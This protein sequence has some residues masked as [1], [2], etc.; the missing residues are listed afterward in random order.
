[1]PYVR[2]VLDLL[3]MMVLTNTAAPRPR[4]ICS[5]QRDFVKPGLH[6]LFNHPGKQ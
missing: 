2:L 3:L 4:D 6:K 5:G 1:M